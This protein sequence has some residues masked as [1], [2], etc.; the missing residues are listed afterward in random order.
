MNQ[1][2]KNVFQLFDEMLK[3]LND[4]KERRSSNN[5]KEEIEANISMTYEQFLKSCRNNE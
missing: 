3:I 1:E 4:L 2:N 5:I